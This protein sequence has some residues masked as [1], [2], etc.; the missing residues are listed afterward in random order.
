MIKRYLVFALLSLVTMLAGCIESEGS[1]SA[2]PTTRSVN[3]QVTSEAGTPLS[4]VT[5]TARSWQV[6]VYGCSREF[7]LEWPDDT[8]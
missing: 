2:A 7:F 4:G 1:G 8:Q 5:V 3:G 6:N